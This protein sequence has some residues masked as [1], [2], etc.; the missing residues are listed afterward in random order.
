MGIDGHTKSDAGCRYPMPWDKKGK[1]RDKFFSLYK[2]MI[3]LRRTVPA[4]A[5]G[6]RK[7]LYDDG[8]ILVVARFMG[9][10]KYIG[11]ISR[12]AKEIKI[13]LWQIGAEK[14]VSDTDEFG[15]HFDATSS[16]GDL[17]IKVPDNAA[18]IIKVD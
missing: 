16:D 7:V 4:F 12:Q 11:I 3:E 8:L 5:K 2:R 18:L 6:G 1:E 9:A 13:P 15:I 10:D 14:A 17:N